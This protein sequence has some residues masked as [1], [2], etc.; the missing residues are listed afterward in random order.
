MDP[1]VGHC[2][3]APCK[4]SMFKPDAGFLASVR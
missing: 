1:C 4:G 3:N 2:R